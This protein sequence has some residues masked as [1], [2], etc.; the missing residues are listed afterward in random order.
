MRSR[1]GAAAL[2][3]VLTAALLA[4]CVPSATPVI[5][6]ATPTATPVFA[7]EAEA[8]A[9]AEAAYKAYEAAVDVSLTKLDASELKLLATG[10]ALTKAVK[11]VADLKSREEHFA[12]TS[13]IN[14]VVLVDAGSV[15]GHSD[16]ENPV[17]IYACLDVSG[18]KL[19]DKRNHSVVKPGAIREFSMVVS[20]LWVKS[21][22]RLVVSREEVWDGKSFCA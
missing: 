7:S 21:S 14:R 3:L 22:N 12:G 10:D 8:L 6:T 18:T 20:L 19:V 1:T 16:S 5:P 4:G 15:L 11:S 2:T 9:A 17:Q 13:V